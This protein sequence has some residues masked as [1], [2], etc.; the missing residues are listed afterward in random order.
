[1]T[2]A[3][4]VFV[5]SREYP[6][7]TVGGTSTVARNLAAGL[8]AEGWEAVVVTSR[9]GA[10][11]DLRERVD[12]VTVHRV[13]TEVVYNAGSGLADD[14][15]LIH[16]RF[17]RAAEA[18]AAELGAPAL[19][20]LPDLFCYPE[21]AMFARRH[22][23]PL[24]NVLLQ[25]FRAIT[26]YDR[27]KHRVTSGVTA[28]RS[29]LLELERKSVLGGDHT[30]FISR[31]LS[32]AITGYYPESTAPHSV[33]H[34]GVDPAEIDSV[35]GDPQWLLRR[36]ELAL[37]PAPLLVGCGRLVPVKGF[38]Q[39]LRAL[40]LLGAVERPGTAEAV[41]PHLALVGVGPEEAELRGLAAASGL[42]ERVTF[43]GDVPR[44]EALGWMSVADVNVV[45]SLWESFCY[46]CAEMMAFGHPVVA[47]AV[48]SLRE[49]IPGPEYGYPVPVS[50]PSGDRTLDPADLAAALRRA[51]ERPE[52][53]RLRGGAAQR[54]IAEHFTN[55]RFARGI[56]ALGERLTAGRPTTGPRADG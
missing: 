11:E 2:D 23:V 43:L 27:D 19:V 5:F 14:S 53:A 3:R 52:E 7:T 25:D 16:R 35:A 41:L 31:A 56:A 28:D 24:V 37:G 48:D 38:A 15:L 33:V 54:R 42:S 45:P 12:G 17:H 26:P 8:V 6:P 39:L 32:D 9:P 55:E 44:R 40:E 29:H 51:L 10:A 1:M 46:V 21:A 13:G 20:A 22:G 36:E 47:S 49:L 34:L 4:R 50:G 30:V 18:L